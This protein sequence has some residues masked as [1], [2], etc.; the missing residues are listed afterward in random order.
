MNMQLN[1]SL[2]SIKKACI[3]FLQRFHVVIFVVI[4]LGG[5]T[6]VVFILN[7]IIVI[8]SESNG[9]TSNTTSQTFDQATIKRIQTLNTSTQTNAPLDLSHGRTNPFVE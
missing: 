8:S 5:A 1:L 3:A 9:Y 2:A 6:V 7:S 4:V